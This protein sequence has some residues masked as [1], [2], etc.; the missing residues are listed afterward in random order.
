M[1]V[2]AAV[3]LILCG[4]FILSCVICAILDLWTNCYICRLMVGMNPPP[5]PMWQGTEC[6]KGCICCP[7]QNNQSAGNPFAGGIYQ[8][9]TTQNDTLQRQ[10]EAQQQQIQMQQQQ[11]MQMM[12]MQNQANQQNSVTFF[13]AVYIIS[14]KMQLKNIFGSILED[15]P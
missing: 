6:C 13:Y 10:I 3:L 15:I 2:F 12:Q 7:E 14:S 11:I 1:G 5:P 4:I 9:Q 8:T